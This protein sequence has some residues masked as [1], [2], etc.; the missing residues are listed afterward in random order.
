YRAELN[1][2]K[3]LTHNFAVFADFKYS[4]LKVSTY[5]PGRTLS[6]DGIDRYLTLGPG[7]QYDSRNIIEYAT[8]GDYFRMSYNHFGFIDKEIN[9]GRFYIENQSFIPI[10]ITKDYFITVASRFYTGL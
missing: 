8:R 10:S 9:F 5:A 2:G 6:P 1:I 7:V 3:K 4:Y